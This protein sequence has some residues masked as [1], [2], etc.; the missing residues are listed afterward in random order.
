MQ[1]TKRGELLSQHVNGV[2]CGLPSLIS[3]YGKVAF[4]I[5]LIY[6]KEGCETESRLYPIAL[7]V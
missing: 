7:S 4:G 5:P 2:Q 3:R 6:V 1:Q